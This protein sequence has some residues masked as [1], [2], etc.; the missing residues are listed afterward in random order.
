MAY[1]PTSTFGRRAALGLFAGVG[2]PSVLPALSPQQANAA[3]PAT[4][5]TVQ[6][7][8]ASFAA[9]G[10][11]YGGGVVIHYDDGHLTDY[12]KAFP[13]HKE[14]GIP[15]ISNVVTGFIDNGP[16]AGEGA[17]MTWNQA[18]EMRD[19]GIWSIGNH[20]LGHIHLTQASKADLRSQVEG[21]Y[22]RI[23]QEMDEPPLWF[24]P[25]Y[26]ET[27]K[28]VEIISARLHARARSAASGT[29]S[30][31]AYTFTSSV[32]MPWDAKRYPG[33]LAALPGYLSDLY[34]R[35]VI[36]GDVVHLYMHEITPTHTDNGFTNVG[37]VEHRALLEGIR[38]RNIPVLDARALAYP[39][40]NMLDDQSFEEGGRGWTLTKYNG[41][42]AVRT[43]QADAHSGSC[44][45]RFANAGAS[46]SG[47]NARLT[48]LNVPVH[49]TR[50]WRFTCWVRASRAAGGRFRADATRGTGLAGVATSNI[51]LTANGYNGQAIA[52]GWQKFSTTFDVTGHNEVS[53]YLE[54]R[55]ADG[56][57]IDIDV[58]SMSLTPSFAYDINGES[59]L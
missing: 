42:T 14:L 11:G 32:I 16:P 45:L 20:T 59:V 56:K 23:L 31:G 8:A 24:A 9:N 52:A 5:T 26:H 15:G 51:I 29:A 19:S 39:R 41:T 34:Y 55:S 46:G 1:H 53:L 3:V 37:E 10:A 47:P 12:A 35:T 36:R 48:S 13:A 4:A 25:P 21:G 17:R 43:G 49:I 28:N 44:Y 50:E 33:G 7:Q 2:L 54:G 30:Q 57:A 58:D 38:Q 18:R 40:L 6:A 27:N 22:A